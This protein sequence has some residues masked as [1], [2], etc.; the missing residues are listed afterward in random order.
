MAT[1][2]KKPKLNK[3]AKSFFAKQ[4]HNKNFLKIGDKGFLVTYNFK[5]KE[6]VREIYKLLNEYYQDQHNAEKN[7]E[8]PKNK[9]GSDDEEEEE[10]DITKQLNAEI[11]KAKQETKEKSNLFQ[12]LETGTNSC[13]FIKT[14]IEDYRNLCFKIVKDLF[15]TKVKKTR[16]TNRFIPVDR[17]CRA[18]ITD[19]VNNAGELFDLHFLKESSTFA[20]NFNRRCN[21]DIIRDDV[22]KELAAL[23]TQKNIKNKVNLKFPEKTILVEIIKGLCLISIIPDYIKLRK[24]NLNEICAIEKTNQTNSE[25]TNNISGEVNLKTE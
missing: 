25:S 16:F 24:Y 8:T 5:E 12:A 20:I 18:N 9:E 21:N 22:I 14:T 17:V 1:P 7:E 10:E 2:A 11:D 23:V 13:V 3:K 19:I 6:S 4:N 15:D